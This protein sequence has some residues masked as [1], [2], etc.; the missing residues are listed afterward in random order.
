LE[1]REK[2]YFLP[3]FSFLSSFLSYSLFYFPISFFL[4]LPSFL[5]FFFSQYSLKLLKRKNPQ[6]NQ[7]RKTEK[8]L[9]K[10]LM[11]WLNKENATS[12]PGGA[13]SG[14]KLQAKMESLSKDMKQKGRL[15]R[16]KEK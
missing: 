4:K 16:K 6:K 15:K 5:P 13:I 7:R 2:K 8:H 9:N 14:D 3:F 11:D 1:K 10:T 12:Q